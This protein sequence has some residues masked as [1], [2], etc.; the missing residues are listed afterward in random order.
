MSFTWDPAELGRQLADDVHRILHGTKPG[1]I[2]IYQSTRFRFTLNL[3]AAK[4]I[5]VAFPPATL[6]RADEVIEEG[7]PSRNP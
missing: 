4:A 3:N 2:P 6:A 7:N 1:D 5:G